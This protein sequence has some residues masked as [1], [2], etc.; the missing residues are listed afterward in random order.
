MIAPLI[1]AGCGVSM[2]FPAAQ[3]S[4]VSAVPREAIGKA[5]E[6]SAP[7]K[8]H[9][10]GFAGSRWGS[11]TAMDAE[12]VIGVVGVVLAAIGLVWAGRERRRRKDLEAELQRPEVVVKMTAYGRESGGLKRIRTNVIVANKGPTAARNVR[13]G[14]RLFEEELLAEQ[15]PVLGIDETRQVSVFVPRKLED[16]M[17]A[18]NARLEEAAFAWARFTDNRGR[19]R[20]VATP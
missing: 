18:G 6:A 11:C 3:N 17:R 7:C 12:L 20:E 13:F 14:L 1:V 2:T 16:R 9:V 8:P 5:A 4:V 19:Q 10:M 15:V